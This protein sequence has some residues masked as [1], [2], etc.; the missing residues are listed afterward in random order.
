VAPP[1]SIL[2]PCRDAAPY[3]GEAIESMRS[4]TFE[5][6]EVIAV[7]DGSRDATPVILAAW[8]GEDGR[9]RVV[10]GHGRG[11][12]AAL[13]TALDVAR[14]EL[15][16][17][18]DADD[19]AEPSRLEEQVR[20]MGRVPGLA[21]CGTGVRYFPRDRVR[22]GARRYESWINSLTTHDEIARDLFIECPMA[23]PT[24]VI[25]RR[26]LLDVGGYRDLGWPE[27]Y[28]L[29]FRLWAAGHRLENLPDVLYRWRET[30][31]RASRTDPRYHPDRFRAAKIHFLRQTLL[32]DGREAVVWGAGPLGKRFARDLASAGTRIRAFVDLSPRKVG[33]EIHGA[34]VVAMDRVAEHVGPG[35]AGA[36]AVAAV[37]QA[38]ARE[39][40]RAECGRLGLVEG[41]DFVAVA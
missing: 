35:P 29:V 34:P 9:V 38:G 13:S 24:L 15:V 14:G 36:L 5:D 6:F 12:V 27:D 21:A 22:D 2:L 37:G 33:Q 40:I 23:H 7:E 10:P 39:A 11:L 19:I 32:A 41:R 18:M 16:A 26:A 25:R 17:R 20:R 31:G 8:A 30:P 1:V 3:L 28:D 4:Q